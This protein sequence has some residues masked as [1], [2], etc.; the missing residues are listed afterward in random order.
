MGV[1]KA[2]SLHEIDETK[3]AAADEK[4]EAILKRVE[5]SEDGEIISDEKIPLYT[6]IGPEEAEIGYER[7]VEFNLGRKDFMLIRKVEN[8]R[9]MGEGHSKSLEPLSRP[10]VSTVMKTKPDTDNTWQIVDLEDMF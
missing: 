3:A 5:A 1:G 9:I 4:F 10:R 8:M 6:D 7:V 2:Y